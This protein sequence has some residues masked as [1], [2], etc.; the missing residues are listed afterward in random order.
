MALSLQGPDRRGA[1]E[2]LLRRRHRFGVPTSS[3]IML[4]FTCVV[5]DFN[6]ALRA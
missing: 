3:R 4:D 6:V 2:Q 1:F 5:V